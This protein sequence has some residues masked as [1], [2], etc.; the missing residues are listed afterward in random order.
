[1]TIPIITAMVTLTRTEFDNLRSNGEI[2]CPDCGSKRTQPYPGC[3]CPPNDL[4]PYGTKHI[5]KWH[6]KCE[7]KK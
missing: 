5:N 7:E 2:A 4:T 3:G 1:M 6:H